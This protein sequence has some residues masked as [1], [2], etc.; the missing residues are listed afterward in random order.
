MPYWNAVNIL[1]IMFIFKKLRYIHKNQDIL[2]N[3]DNQNLAQAIYC[4]LMFDY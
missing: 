3:Q 2:K 4:F 1:L